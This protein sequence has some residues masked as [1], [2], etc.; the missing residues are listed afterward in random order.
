MSCL[1]EQWRQTQIV[2]LVGRGGN[3]DDGIC[4]ARHLASRGS[5]GT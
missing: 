5:H 1:K 3:G 2:V 4:A